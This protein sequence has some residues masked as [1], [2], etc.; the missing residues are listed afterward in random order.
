MDLIYWHMNAAQGGANLHLGV[1][2]HPGA[3]LHSVQIAHMNTALFYIIVSRYMNCLLTQLL[4]EQGDIHNV[5]MLLA[6][7]LLIF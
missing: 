6:L 2:L 3:K 5:N 7:F 1:N 4:Q